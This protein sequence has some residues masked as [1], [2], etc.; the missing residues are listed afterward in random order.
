MTDELAMWIL[1]PSTLENAVQEY[2]FKDLSLFNDKEFNPLF[3]LCWNEMM[4]AIEKDGT[5]S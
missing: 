3:E 1:Y 4:S 5:S 2:L